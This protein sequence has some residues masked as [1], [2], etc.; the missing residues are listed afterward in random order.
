M[1][2]DFRRSWFEIMCRKVP[3]ERG[4][5]RLVPDPPSEEQDFLGGFDL[6]S[7][8]PGNRIGEGRQSIRRVLQSLQL[9]KEFVHLLPGT[10]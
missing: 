2:V 4:V 10:E 7:D 3:C 8:R 9:G 1:D 6:G 5:E